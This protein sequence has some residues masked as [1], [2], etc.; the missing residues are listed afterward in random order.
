MEAPTSTLP[1]ALPLPLERWTEAS[2]A[3]E[4][5]VIVKEAAGE[6]MGLDLVGNRL[7]PSFRLGNAKTGK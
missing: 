2:L 6:G 7:V 3:E 1:V 5:A 4:G